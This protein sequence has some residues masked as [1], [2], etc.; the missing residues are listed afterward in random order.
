MKTQIAWFAGAAF[1]A[2]GMSPTRAWA[3]FGVDLVPTGLR[4]TEVVNDDVTGSY[5][6]SVHIFI[7]NT[8]TGAWDRSNATMSVAIG[9]TVVKGV[10]YG[11]TAGG[12]FVL[13]GRIAPGKR[14]F[15]SLSLPSGTLHHCQ[16]VRVR[17]DLGH[18][19]QTLI[20]AL[21]LNDSAVLGAL[22]TTRSTACA[23]LPP[24]H[25]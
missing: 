24:P 8:G 9:D 15:V 11:P 23:M 2:M 6:Q 25:R 1:V 20:R 5:A 21:F 17:I 16:R 19:H 13:G 7:K 4:F 18:E 14:G 22:D 3:L 12:G 10:I